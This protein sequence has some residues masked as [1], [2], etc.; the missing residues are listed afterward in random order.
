MLTPEK[1]KDELAA[2]SDGYVFCAH[3]DEMNDPMEAKHRVSALLKRHSR[4]PK[5][6]A[7]LEEKIR[8]LG[9]AS[10]SE[11]RLIEPMWA[12][13][14]DGFR[15]M[16]VAYSVNRLNDALPFGHGLARMGYNEI[17]PLLSLTTKDLN[18]RA[19]AVLCAKTLRWSH[20]REWRLFAPA[21]GPAEYGSVKCVTA[22]Y[23]GARMDEHTKARLLNVLEQRGIPAHIMDVES[24]TLKFLRHPTKS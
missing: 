2:L 10:F 9:V 5:I 15:G 24:Y 8:E 7:Q 14:A 6:A 1:I 22:V 23:L 21:R 20:E 17:P 4:Y 3:Y 11:S 16:C 12:Y 19:R 18:E 13:Y